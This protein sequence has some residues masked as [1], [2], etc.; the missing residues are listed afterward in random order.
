MQ[1][2]F[3]SLTSSMWFTLCFIILLRTNFLSSAFDPIKSIELDN[4]GHLCHYV[5]RCLNSNDYSDNEFMLGICDFMCD[6]IQHVRDDL[7]LYKITAKYMKHFHKY[8]LD[9]ALK[10]E[11]RSSGAK[12]VIT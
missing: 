3:S 9:N 10:R 11:K 6:E 5:D 1:I 8:E 7:H 2:Y 4:C 12:K